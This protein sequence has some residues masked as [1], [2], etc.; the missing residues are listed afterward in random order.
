ML[1]DDESIGSVAWVTFSSRPNEQFLCATCTGGLDVKSRM[2]R[3]GA[4]YLFLYD[5]QTGGKL[6]MLS[7][8]PANAEADCSPLFAGLSLVHKTLIAGSE[9]PDAPLESMDD[10]APQVVQDFHG[11]V[12]I[13]YGRNLRLYDLGTKRMLRKAELLGAVAHRLVTVV[14]SGPRV[15]TAD[16]MESVLAWQYSPAENR[17]LR[18]AE[19]MVPRFMTAMCLVDHGT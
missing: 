16:V 11:R 8:M 9:E 4:A 13:S 2:C 14:V 7:K 18:L 6:E 3:Y 17:F 15:W 10:I 19:D 1:G 12:L 5:K